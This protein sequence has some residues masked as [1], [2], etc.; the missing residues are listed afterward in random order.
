MTEQK[1]TR[2][3]A[4]EKQLCDELIRQAEANDLPKTYS[5]LVIDRLREKGIEPNEETIEQRIIDVKARRRS[6]FQ[7][8]LAI[9]DVALLEKIKRST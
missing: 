6:D 8:A 4:R 9:Y 3:T 7:I 1:R 5:Y 2:A